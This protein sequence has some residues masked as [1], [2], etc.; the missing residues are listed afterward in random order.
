MRGASG[1]GRSRHDQIAKLV[2][3]LRPD[4]GHGVELVD[5]LE[6][7]V[8]LAVVENLLRGY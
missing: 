1:L 2:E 8:L 4:P 5:R 7:A 3:P 6:G